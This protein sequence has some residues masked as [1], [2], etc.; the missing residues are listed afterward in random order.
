M[1]RLRS[2]PEG[3][4]WKSQDS[5]WLPAL[6]SVLNHCACAWYEAYCTPFMCLTYVILLPL[7]IPDPGLNA[8]LGNFM[9]CQLVWREGCPQYCPLHAQKLPIPFSAKA[10]TCSTSWREGTKQ[11][12]VRQI[13]CNV[14]HKFPED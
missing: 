8:P 13:L 4:Q 2:Q 7:H 6:A 11:L 9:S 12:T 10:Q 5:D 3:V 1:V 14:L